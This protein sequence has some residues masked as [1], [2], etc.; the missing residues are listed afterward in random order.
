MLVFVHQE[1]GP[2]VDA[3]QGFVTWQAVPRP[4]L[5][6][7]RAY[8]PVL[9]GNL[10]QPCQLSAELLQTYLDP[11]YMPPG[12]KTDVDSVRAFRLCN[13]HQRAKCFMAAYHRQHL[14]PEGL[15]TRGGL[16]CSL[17]TTGADIRFFSL[18]RKSLLAMERL[19][20]SCCLLTTNSP[21]ACMVMPSRSPQAALTISNALRWLAPHVRLDPAEVVRRC[22]DER[23][24]SRN[25]VLLK[26]KQG[27]LWIKHDDL[28]YVL[29][30]KALRAEIETCM[31]SPPAQF[32]VL[33]LGLIE[34]GAFRCV[35]Q[36]FVSVHIPVDRAL[37]RLGAQTPATW[38][39]PQQIINRRLC[40]KSQLLSSPL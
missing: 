34:S 30:D 23:L 38:T 15:L 11:W 22:I 9:P 26:V 1:T 16:L 4:S 7:M 40:C 24:H 10:A 8:F 20:H 18:H 25:S 6:I 2:G 39:C 3:A 27:W 32:H 13:P 12:Q 21:C 19:G 33:Q 29:A 5:A 14:L 17:L 35:R 28:G 36:V 37:Q 31:R